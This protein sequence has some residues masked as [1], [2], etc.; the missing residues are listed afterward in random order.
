MVITILIIVIILIPCFDYFYLLN[1]LLWP[2]TPNGHSRDE[3]VGYNTEC[4]QGGLP[5]TWI[6]SQA[7]F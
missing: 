7:R 3:P 6:G 2:G 1:L 4:C 5:C